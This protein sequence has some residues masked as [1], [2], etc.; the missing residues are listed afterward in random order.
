MKINHFG[1]N[2]SKVNKPKNQLFSL[3][4]NETL[5]KSNIAFISISILVILTIFDYSIFTNTFNLNQGYFF[6]YLLVPSIKEQ[7]L[8]IIFILLPIIV[9]ILIFI[10]FYLVHYKFL[11]FIKD[12]YYE[13]F[14][15]KFN[16][17]CECKR[18]GISIISLFIFIFGDFL[19][20]YI[21]SI[22]FDFLK[23]YVFISYFTILVTI[24]IFYMLYNTL[25]IYLSII[26]LEKYNNLLFYLMIA[27]FFKLFILIFIDGNIGILILLNLIILTP[28]LLSKLVNDKIFYNQKTTSKKEYSL[29]IVIFSTIA[30]VI[31]YTNFLFY[32]ISEIQKN[33]Y[34]KIK[35]W[36]KLPNNTLSNSTLALLLSPLK[37]IK[38]NNFEIDI[39]FLL[40]K[41]ENEKP[42]L[43]ELIL[44]INNNF[45]NKKLNFFYIPF[46]EYRIFFIK[47]DNS[48]KNI[49]TFYGKFDDDKL[50]KILDVG[51][52]ILEADNKW[53]K[54]YWEIQPSLLNTN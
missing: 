50:V 27:V 45:L 31:I 35:F 2:K 30:F 40:N 38:D 51:Y 4:K 17:L 37:I 15:K 21:V 7:P 48:E 29:P 19:I 18:T 25:I 3:I 1:T 16:S 8:L 26:I 34:S 14:Y 42:E 13:S 53:Q 9:I 43:K 36:Q 22:P 28:L 49:L 6:N 24:Y 44:D 47:S 33:P 52:I 10:I 39:I 32:Y 12:K 5:F 23:K 11:L 54:T 46:Q 41:I 20:Y